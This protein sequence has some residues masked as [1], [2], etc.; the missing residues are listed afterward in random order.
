MIRRSTPKRR[1]APNNPNDPNQSEVGSEIEVDEEQEMMGNEAA[2]QRMQSS[3]PPPSANP[4]DGSGDVDPWAFN[5]FGGEYRSDIDGLAWDNGLKMTSEVESVRRRKQPPQRP[6][7][8][9][10]VSTLVM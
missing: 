4:N 9:K 5:L 2:V 6:R 10:E 8:V 7:L 1:S 3:G